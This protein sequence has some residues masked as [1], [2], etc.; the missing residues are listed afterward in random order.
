MVASSCA[1][2]AVNRVVR[3]DAQRYTDYDALI[4]LNPLTRT[5]NPK[6]INSQI[7]FPIA[8]GAVIAQTIKYGRQCIMTV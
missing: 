1:S 7:N 8:T 5:L 2:T 6:T 4:L 3:P